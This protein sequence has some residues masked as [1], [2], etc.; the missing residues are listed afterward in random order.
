MQTISHT[1]SFGSENACP[2]K[3]G[4]LIEAELRRQGKTVTW[5]SR[6]I[7]CARRNVYDIFEREYIDTGLLF[8]I[9]R[10]LRHDFFADYSKMLM[11]SDN[12]LQ[13]VDSL[14]V[15]EGDDEK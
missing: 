4:R 1:Y 2:L 3:I 10:I 11:Q 12:K 5:F 13:S 6:E 15:N 14:G 9:S 8:I 7:H